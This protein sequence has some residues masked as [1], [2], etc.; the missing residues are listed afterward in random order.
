MPTYKFANK[1]APVW[2]HTAGLV[3]GLEIWL[4][5]CER[6][7]ERAKTQKDQNYWRGRRYAFR[8]VIEVI[9]DSTS[10]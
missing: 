9:K 4:K 1:D 3:S 6:Q 2:A 10:I 8:E 5:D 7:L